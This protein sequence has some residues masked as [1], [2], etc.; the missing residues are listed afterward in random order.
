MLVL[1]RKVNERVLI[2]DQIAV[3]IVR[4]A[5]NVVRIGIEAPPEMAVIREEL[6]VDGEMAPVAKSTPASETPFRAPLRPR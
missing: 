4:I 5:N 1:S 6:A 3:T 2:G